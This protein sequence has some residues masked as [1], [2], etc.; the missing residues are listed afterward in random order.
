MATL[1]EI[2]NWFMTGKKPT[3]AQ[4]WASWGSF[5][6]KGEQIPQTAVSNL[7]TVLNAKAEK[8]QFDAH[9]TDENTHAAILVEPNARITALESF[10]LA[11]VAHTTGDETFSGIKTFADGQII[12]NKAIGSAIKSEIKAGN[13]TADRVH[14]LPDISGTI[15]LVANPNGLGSSD[16]SG[17]VVF[18]GT[19]GTLVAGNIYAFSSLGV[20]ERADTINLDLSSRTLGIA[21]GT[22]L[23]DGILISGYARFAAQS[24]YSS[25]TLG[26]RIY[27]NGIVIS[28]TVPTATGNIVRVLGY[29]V[30]AVAHTI[31]FNPDTTWI[32]L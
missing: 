19:S 7:T 15:A 26:Q 12:I 14:I 21:L 32:Q 31:Y 17:C 27:L 9:K 30:D 11:N 6:N 24:Q 4:F 22:S 8:A 20:W 29:C 2:Y 18:Y 25:L 1:A 10:D 28:P 16:V 23:A 3:Q 5:W 13:L